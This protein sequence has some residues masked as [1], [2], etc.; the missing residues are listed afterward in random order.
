M[1]LF[2][3]V[4][5]NVG[6]SNKEKGDDQLGILLVLANTAGSNQSSNF[7]LNLSNANALA[8][9]NTSSTTS[10][11]ANTGVS[12]LYA[13]DANGNLTIA[14]S[15]SSQTVKIK[16]IY[17]GTK[18]V[19]LLFETNVKFSDGNVVRNCALARSDLSGNVT[20]VDFDLAAMATVPNSNSIQTKNSDTVQVDANDG[21]FYYGVNKF[22]ITSLKYASSEGVI[23]TI[24]LPE[25][26]LQY[27]YITSGNELIISHIE[28]ATNQRYLS[29]LSGTSRLDVSNLST[30]T[31]AFQRS[32]GNYLLNPGLPNSSTDD[33]IKEYNPTTKTLTTKI[34]CSNIPNYDE[35]NST[36][37]VGRLQDIRK[38]LE[39]GGVTYFYS[40][41]ESSH[42][43]N[44]RRHL[45]NL[46]KFTSDTTLDW[47]PIGAD[48]NNIAVKSIEAIEAVGGNKVLVWGYT[49]TV[50]NTDGSGT[51]TQ[52]KTDNDLA[53]KLFDVGTKTTSTIFTFP[54]ERIMVR[55]MEY[56][57][58]LNR[59]FILGVDYSTNK[60]VSGYYDLNSSK[61]NFG[62]SSS[63][64]ITQV[65]P[66][67]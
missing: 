32:S 59:V 50:T 53:L 1:V 38:V 34:H 42:V 17:P 16:K 56:S 9:T 20:C 21:I 28:K 39:V 14:I 24:T 13:V 65:A 25:S 64:E 19:Y 63:L 36:N 49:T 27:F 43:S 5:L 35:W 31:W 15:G 52:T 54:G 61:Y 11:R 6:C 2:L 55:K 10:V 3:F 66:I 29:V 47:L 33:Q 45:G 44:V 57:P 62:K 4:V 30:N 58:A 46:Y 23:K 8:V 51:V 26:R 41:H 60:Q 48:S 40:T 7:T 22:G 67:R 12:N 18:F 37:F